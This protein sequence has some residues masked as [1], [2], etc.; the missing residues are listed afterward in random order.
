MAVVLFVNAFVTWVEESLL[1]Q[2]HMAPF[3]SVTADK[4]LTLLLNTIAIDISCCVRL[5]Y[6]YLWYYLIHMVWWLTLYI[7][8][9]SMIIECI[10]K[11]NYT[12][13]ACLSC[14]MQKELVS[15]VGSYCTL[16]QKSLVAMLHWR[17][18]QDFDSACRSKFYLKNTK[19]QI[20]PEEDTSEVPCPNHRPL[21]LPDRFS[22]KEEWN[23]WISHLDNVAA[24]NTWN[25]AQKLLWLNVHLTERTQTTFQ[26]FPDYVQKNYEAAKKALERFE[27]ECRK[28][29]TRQNSAVGGER[30]QKAG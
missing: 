10:L 23:Q 12:S 24:V 27:P 13:C 16:T 28:A 26:H 14:Y 19:K 29:G 11:F 5:D 6:V 17:S 3:F 20:M 7:H 4:C 22:D 1:K 8:T 15:I 9:C 21:V 30:R 18:R 25:E 2:L